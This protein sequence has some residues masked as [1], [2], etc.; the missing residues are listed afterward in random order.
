M[1]RELP[2]IVVAVIEYHSIYPTHLENILLRLI[3]YLPPLSLFLAK[4]LL[5]RVI[6]TDP[7]P[8][9]PLTAETVTRKYESIILREWGGKTTYFHQEYADRLDG[10]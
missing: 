7:W 1:R 6:M 10:Y 8:I 2:E 4:N 9:F 5:I 3:H